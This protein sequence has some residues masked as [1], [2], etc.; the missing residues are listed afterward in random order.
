MKDLMFGVL[1]VFVLASPLFA[2]IYWMAWATND[3]QNGKAIYNTVGFP[4]KEC[5][6]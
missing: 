5:K 6:K 2:L 3:C 1:F 4:L